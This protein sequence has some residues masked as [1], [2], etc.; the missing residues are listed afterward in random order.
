MLQAV[1]DAHVVTAWL[2]HPRQYRVTAPLPL[3]AYTQVT[4]A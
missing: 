4:V 3:P 1:L 2:V